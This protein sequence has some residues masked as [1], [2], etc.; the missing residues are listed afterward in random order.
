MR[1]PERERD[2]GRQGKSERQT[3]R[4]THTHTHRDG[5]REGKEQEA[6][7]RL[8]CSTATEADYELHVSQ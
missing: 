3:E 2:C 8:V 7:A 6:E 4:D 5:G 1:E